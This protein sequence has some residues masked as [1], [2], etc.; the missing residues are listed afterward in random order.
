[1]NKIEKEKAEQK[2]I[3]NR[4]RKRKQRENEPAGIYLIKNTSNNK[5]Y[6]GKSSHI[7]TRKV[8]HFSMLRKNSHKNKDLQDDYNL[9]GEESFEFSII[10]KVQDNTSEENL[11][12]KEAEHILK[13][14]K[15]RKDIYNISYDPVFVNMLL[16]EYLE[17]LSG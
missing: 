16:K 8:N 7:N 2:R 4:N 1:M 17:L 10:E 3:A 6:V 5:E 13:K 15:E 12:R 11:L 9:F 14:I